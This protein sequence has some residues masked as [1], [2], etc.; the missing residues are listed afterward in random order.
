[1]SKRLKFWLSLALILVVVTIVYYPTLSHML[2]GESYL[3][4]TE[5]LDDTTASKMIS[6][7]WNYESARTIAP[8]GESCFLNSLICEGI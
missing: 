3:Y 6:K 8:A 4:F 7:W 2:R 1:M 5:T